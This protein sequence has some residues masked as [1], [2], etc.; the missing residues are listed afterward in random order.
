MN[1]IELGNPMTIAGPCAAESREQVLESA[2]E[3]KRRGINVVRLSLW[4][5][6]T[7]P[8]F[9]GL[10]EEEI[11]LLIEVAEMGL[12]PATEVILPSHAEQVI[13]NVLEHTNQNILVWIGSR[14]QNHMV[15]REIARVV[16]GEHRVMLMV[17]N[18]PWRDKNH[19]EGIV[20]HVLAGGV[21]EEQLLLCH[22]GFSPGV[23]GFRNTPDFDMA[24]DLKKTTGIPIILDPSHIGGNVENVIEA[25]KQGMRFQK[26]GV[27]F[28][29]M[30]IEVHPNPLEAKTDSKQQL[31][32]GDFDSL[33][34]ELDLKTENPIPMLT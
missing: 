32:W 34:S 3:A 31:T 8:G 5:P 14:N 33:M 24:I 19:W 16:A 6:R 2:Q 29:G 18:Q 26:N 22:R 30:M 10:G 15:Q 11:P 27:G 25:A 17:K 1:R 9:D 28:D 21:G 12:T 20:D 23:N 7:K 4:K 13:N